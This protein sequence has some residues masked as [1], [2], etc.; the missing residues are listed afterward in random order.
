MPSL[1]VFIVAT[2]NP[3]LTTVTVTP[4]TGAALGSMNFPHTHRIGLSERGLSQIASPL[5]EAWR[6]NNSSAQLQTF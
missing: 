2:F 5:E 3:S 4:E 1:P 6:I